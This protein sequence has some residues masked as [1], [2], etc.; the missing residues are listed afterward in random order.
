VAE[1]DDFD[2]AVQFYRNVLGL[3]EELYTESE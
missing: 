2:G 1:A 3:E